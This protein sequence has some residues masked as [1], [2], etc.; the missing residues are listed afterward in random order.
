MYQIDPEM[1]AM[2]KVAG[3][4]LSF[5]LLYFVIKAGVR[6]GVVAAWKQCN[7]GNKP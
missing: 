2:M 6:A 7:R 5:L 3:Y 1:I 4:A